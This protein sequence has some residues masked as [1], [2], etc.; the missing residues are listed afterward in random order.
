MLIRFAKR[1]AIH[2]KY[3]IISIIFQLIISKKGRIPC[4][5]LS[6]LMCCLDSLAF[7]IPWQ[8]SQLMI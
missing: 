5:T 6:L 1:I 8:Q 2:N 4:S 7:L 3:I